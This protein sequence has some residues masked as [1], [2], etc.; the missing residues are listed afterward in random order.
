M[1]PPIGMCTSYIH[2]IQTDRH[3][4]ILT[5][6]WQMR[7]VLYRGTGVGVEYLG[8]SKQAQQLWAAAS[9]LVLSSY[10]A[11]DDMHDGARHGQPMP[12]VQV[13]SCLRSQLLVRHCLSSAPVLSWVMLGPLASLEGAS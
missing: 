3:L 2:D 6:I 1:A 10:A 9:A 8:G 4:D 5:S 7:G 13:T 11:V 12:H